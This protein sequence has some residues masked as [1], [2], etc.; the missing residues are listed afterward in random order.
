MRFSVVVLLFA[1]VVTMLS[2]GRTVYQNL[3]RQTDRLVVSPAVATPISNDAGVRAYLRTEHARYGL[4][5]DLSGLALDRVQE[6][7]SATHYHYRQMLDGVPVA[8]AGIVV[9]VDGNGAITRVFNTTWPVPATVRAKAT[10]QLDDRDA[11]SVAWHEL[12]V[13]GELMSMPH[14]EK[15]WRVTAGRFDLV[16]RVEMFA[17]A[18][19][20][21]WQVTLDA[22]DGRV[23]EVVERSRDRRDTPEKAYAHYAGDLSDLDRAIENVRDRQ[24]QRQTWEQTL[25][26]KDG[27]TGQG[28]I[29]DPDPRT[30]T[31]NGD[32]RDNSPE[33]DFA[34]AYVWRDLRDISQTGDGQYVLTGPW[35]TIADI[36]G[37]FTPPSSTPDGVWDFPRGNNA[38]NDAISYYHVDTSQRYIQSLGFVGNKGIQDGPIDIDSDGQN[39]FDQSIYAGGTGVNYLSFGHGCVDDSEDADVIIHEYGHAIQQ[40]IVPSWFRNADEGGMGEGFADYWAA[41]YR[42]KTPNG[43]LW[44]PNHIFHWDAYHEFTFDECWPGRRLDRLQA[45]YDP[46]QTYPDH[47]L[48]NI[49]VDGSIYQFESDELWSTPLWQ[50]FLNLYHQGIPQS[51]IDQIVLEAHFGLGFGITMPEMAAATVAAARALYPDGP[52]AQVFQNNFARHNILDPVTQFDYSS[53]H[54][55]PGTSGWENEV[56]I[57]NPNTTTATVVATVYEGD[58]SAIGL[59]DYAP[60]SQDTL[61]LAAGETATFTP[62]GSQQR[63]IQFSSDQPIA[64]TTVVRRT[65][66]GLGSEKATIPL[67]A[68]TEVSQTVVFPHVPADRN[69][70]W[71][72]A[73]LLNPNGEAV[74]LTYELIGDQGSDLTG[75]LSDAAPARLEPRQKYV[76]LLADGLFDDTASEEKVSWVRITSAGG[77]ISGFQLYGY[78]ATSGEIATSGIISQADQAR[79]FWPIRASLTDADFNGFSILNPTDSD[80]TATVRVV[81]KDGSQSDPA[82]LTIPA[83]AKK[84]GLNRADFFRFPSNE[85]VKLFDLNDGTNIQAVLVT[86]EAPLRIFE[87]V[88][89]FDGATLDGTAVTG[90]TN[91]VVFP[92]ARGTLE[93]MRVGYQGEVSVRFDG[94]L[95]TTPNPLVPGASF[96]LAIPEG[97]TVVEVRGALFQATIIEKD[98]TERTLATINGKQIAYQP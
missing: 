20:G 39:G 22:V 18:P 1:S 64:G 81:Y 29:F 50:S 7:L 97:T 88:G 76:S 13:H 66:E 45:Q 42:F 85:D 48:Y 75:L 17:T 40:W 27:L 58:S 28:H 15:L 36:E 37:P 61:T 89:D 87:L 91:H 60:A 71:S 49:I 86:S 11:L 63:W 46:N 78:N 96:Q 44:Q 6:S 23:L 30:T 98:D 70:F 67:L 38:L 93:V 5:E 21:L 72:G 2:A 83:R 90:A 35:A 68:E 32:L 55:S 74:D 8:G 25:K 10:I 12:R 24:A 19:F 80:A 54:I 53:I 4:P 26:R 69:T 77:E 65:G 14:A 95:Q 33:E 52:H 43:P 82:D 47:A 56:V 73:V 34:D 51:E 59:A 84:L 41:S 3:D 57:H 92:A 9:S 79:A 31:M 62:G 94:T 16:W